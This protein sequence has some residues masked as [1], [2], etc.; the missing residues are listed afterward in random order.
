MIPANIGPGTRGDEAGRGCHRWGGDASARRRFTTTFPYL[1]RSRRAFSVGFFRSRSRSC[2]SSMSRISSGHLNRRPTSSGYTVSP[3]LSI[4]RVYTHEFL[5]VSSPFLSG[6]LSI[7]SVCI[8]SRVLLYVRATLGRYARI[9]FFLGFRGVSL[10]FV[11]MGVLFAGAVLFLNKF[12]MSSNFYIIANLM[13]FFHR[14]KLWWSYSMNNINYTWDIT[15]LF[16]TLRSTGLFCFS[17]S[18]R[19]I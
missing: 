5:F 4:P 10:Y 1:P 7:A 16:S 18:K 9:L 14:I 6:S 3:F 13:L 15:D 12:V 2:C 19:L 11:V 8:R 17:K